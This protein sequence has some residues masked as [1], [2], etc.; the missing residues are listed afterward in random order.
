MRRARPACRPVGSQ[1]PVPVAQGGGRRM[2]LLSGH[3]RALRA[4]R[5]SSGVPTNADA[6]TFEEDPAG[7]ASLVG[8]VRRALPSF[9]PEPVSFETCLYTSTPDEGF[10]LDRCGP[11]LIASTCSGHGFKF[12]PIVGELIA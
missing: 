9:D 3:R 12:G 7:R 5:A 4:R 1:R 6:R 11:V 8:Y 10:I 2:H